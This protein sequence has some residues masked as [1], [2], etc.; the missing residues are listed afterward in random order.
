MSSKLLELETLFDI[1][2]AIS[3]VLEI[4]ELA[5]DVLWRSVGI[6]NASKGM[7]LIQEENNLILKPTA[8]FNW[9]EKEVL[10]SKRLNI[11]KVITEKNKD[12]YNEIKIKIFLNIFYYF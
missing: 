6:L 5:E 7:L 2:V 9:E 4:D 8:L 12:R 11:F 3:S 10:L 1:S